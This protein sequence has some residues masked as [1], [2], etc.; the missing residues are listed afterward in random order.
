MSPNSPGR[1]KEGRTQENGRMALIFPISFAF[2]LLLVS[3]VALL[4]SVLIEQYLLLEPLRGGEG[5]EN[6]PAEYQPL[7]H[8]TLFTMK[9]LVG[10]LKEVGFA[11]FIS[12]VVIM[13]VERRAKAEIAGLLEKSQTAQTQELTTFVEKLAKDYE[14]FGRLTARNVFDAVLERELPKRYVA[15]VIDSS[16]SVNIIR[17]EYKSTYILSP[18]TEEDTSTYGSVLE[19]KLKLDIQ[20]FYRLRNVSKV[21]ADFDV[22]ISIPQLKGGRLSELA[23]LTSLAINSLEKTG[24][25]IAEAEHP[26]EDGF[27][28]NFIFKE[29]IKPGQR[30]EVHGSYTVVKDRS[31]TELWTSIFPTMAAELD[32]QLKVPGWPAPQGWS[33]R[34]IS[35]AV[36]R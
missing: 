36:S 5:A 13:M 26:S 11:T 15:E 28:K 22:R 19:K 27:Y 1:R 24:P 8:P 31:D 35:P 23:Y 4:A 12:F 9:S 32:V 2:L 25:Q 34:F 3:T 18:Y 7:S 10:F 16:I 29:K 17:E 21:E 14:T 6:L 20:F 33:A 30:F